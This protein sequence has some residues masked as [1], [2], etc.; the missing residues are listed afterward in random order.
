MSK[1]VKQ[2]PV[3]SDTTR[4]GRASIWAK[5][6]KNSKKRTR[7]KPVKLWVPP[8]FEKLDFGGPVQKLEWLKGFPG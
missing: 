8:E 3:V 1:H 6:R 5:K 7:G 2:T 4:K